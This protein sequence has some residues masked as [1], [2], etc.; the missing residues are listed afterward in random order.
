MWSKP[1][2]SRFIH[3]NHPQQ[4]GVEEPPQSNKVTKRQG[5]TSEI[6]ANLQKDDQ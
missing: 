6:K 1:Q 5:Q 3:Y 4:V 2:N